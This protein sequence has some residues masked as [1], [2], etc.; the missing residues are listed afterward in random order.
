LN[1]IFLE[2]TTKYNLEVLDVRIKAAKLEQ[3][4]ID[5]ARNK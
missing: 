5:V 2:L 3:L 1:E 4:F